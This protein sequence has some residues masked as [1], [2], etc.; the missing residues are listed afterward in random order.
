MPKAVRRKPQYSTKGPKVIDPVEFQK[1]CWPHI[2]LYQQQK[3]VLYSLQDNIE[4]FVPAGNELGKDFIAAMAIIWFTCTRR[5]VRGLATSVEGGQLED[6]LWGEIRRLM[7]ESEVHLPLQYNHL[8]LRQIRKDGSKVPLCEFRGKVAEKG[9]A[10]LGRHLP[11]HDLP[12]TM[13][14][15][16]EAS[17]VDNS[18]YET[19]TTWADRILVVGNPYECTNFFYNAVKNGDIE[20][21]SGKGLFRKV[22][23]IKGEHSP[24]V[25][26]QEER[27]KRGLETNDKV[28]IPGVLTYEKYILRRKTWDERRQCIGLDAEFYEGR[29]A[30]MY[31]PDWLTHSHGRWQVLNPRRPGTAM[32]IDTAEGVDDTIWTIVDDAGLIAQIV[33]KTPDTSVIADRTIAYARQYGVRGSC[34]VID[35]GGG[36][37]QIADQLRRKGIPVKT[38]AFGEAIKG[39][40][41]TS[42]LKEHLKRRSQREEDVTEEKYLYKN[43]RAQLYHALRL[44][45]D[46]YSDISRHFGIFGIP[47]G[48]EELLRQLKPIPLLHDGEGR[49]WMPPKRKKHERDKVQTITSM[50]G[51]SPDHADSLVLAVHGLGMDTKKKSIRAFR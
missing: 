4:T 36:G 45:I 17:G 42:Q 31:P 28:I 32:G 37:K 22:I 5:P 40:M 50:I 26:Y 51:R 24:N 46:P 39:Q 14:M 41:S 6:V 11:G 38:V 21:P 25:R 15:I 3:E 44:R 2:T 35:R 23:K 33:Q 1:K 12:R 30:R 18:V 20:N 27:L 19:A 48:Y 10:L 47:E 49:I 13:L 43:R 29:H 16:D 7:D 9:E 34:I 8:L